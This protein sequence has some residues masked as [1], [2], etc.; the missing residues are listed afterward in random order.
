MKKIF[1]IILFFI[2]AG[3]C[4]GQQVTFQRSYS[5]NYYT[6][7]ALFGDDVGFCVKQ[8]FD[9]GYIIVGT[10]HLLSVTE[11]DICLI[12]TDVNGDTLWTRFFGGNYNEIGSSVIQT[13]DSGY[14]IAGSTETPTTGN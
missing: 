6:G 10:T 9:G 5:K 1:S 11:Q 3:N 14:V 2:S 8:T 4:F 13:S 7:T 12:K